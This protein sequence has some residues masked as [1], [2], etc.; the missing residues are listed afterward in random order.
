MSEEILEGMNEQPEFSDL[1]GTFVFAIGE[2]K[3]KTL[4]AETFGV[5]RTD[6]DG[7]LSIPPVYVKNDEDAYILDDRNNREYV[8]IPNYICDK[9]ISKTNKLLA[10]GTALE[11]KANRFTYKEEPIEFYKDF[12]CAKN[13][14]SEIMTESLDRLL[15]DTYSETFDWILE[16]FPTY[17]DWK[18]DAVY[19]CIPED[20]A[21]LYAYKH[22]ENGIT[23]QDFIN[24]MKGKLGGNAYLWDDKMTK[25]FHAYTDEKIEER[26]IRNDWESTLS[27]YTMKNV[28]EIS[29]KIGY[30]F[31]DNDIQTLAKLHKNGNEDM[32]SK[33]ED[34]LDDC[35]FHYE[36]GKFA[37]GRYDEWLEPKGKDAIERD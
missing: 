10:Y 18:R 2:Y 20:F 15:Y 27:Q 32:K 13:P 33:I 16:S 1:G 22:I 25:E 4:Y 28:C 6:K 37:N 34:L 8:H 24:E 21:Y 3:G 31:T 7:N 36:S 19:I 14:K 5:L 11:G 12:T 23:E 9:L 17:E 30:G 35:N 26:E 29:G